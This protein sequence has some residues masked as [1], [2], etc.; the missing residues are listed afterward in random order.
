MLP[1][2]TVTL[3]VTGQVFFRAGVDNRSFGS[4]EEIVRTIFSPLIFAGLVIYALSTILW[5][6]V[7]TR[8]PISQAYPMLALAYPAMLIIAKF[9]FNEDISL[10]RW[11]GV[12]VVCIGVVLVAK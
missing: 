4:I 5:L 7:L 12:G 1:L 6:Y 3:F 8:I 9:L 10:I 2:M 11:I